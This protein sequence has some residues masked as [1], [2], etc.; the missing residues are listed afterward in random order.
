MIGTVDVWGFQ[1][2][3]C[4]NRKVFILMICMGFGE[5]MKLFLGHVDGRDMDQALENAKKEKPGVKNLYM[6]VGD[7][8]MI[9]FV[10]RKHDSDQVK[11]VVVHKFPCGTEDIGD[12][13]LEQDSKPVNGFPT[14]IS[15]IAY[16]EAIKR[17]ARKGMNCDRNTWGPCVACSLGKK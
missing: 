12:H 3:D 5:N 9:E 7:N 16:E 15:I 1:A 10:V 11:E 2:G 13:D 14:C 6:R 8:N 4:G 17:G